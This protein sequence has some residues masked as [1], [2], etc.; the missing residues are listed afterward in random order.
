MIIYLL[1]DERQ[2]K[3]ASGSVGGAQPCQGWG[4][5]FES[6]LA[7]PLNKKK[8]S[9][10]ISSFCLNEAHRASKFEVSTPF[11]SSQGRGPLDLLRRLALILL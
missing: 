3:C 5:G 10:R 11:R 7:L 4:R 9:E 2:T 6:R 1:F 8:I